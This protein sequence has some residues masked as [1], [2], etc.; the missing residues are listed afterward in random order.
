M[1][2]DPFETVQHDVSGSQ[3]LSSADLETPQVESEYKSRKRR[4]EGKGG[5]YRLVK[6]FKRG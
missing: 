5:K 3:T 2:G 4:G 1:F 6:M